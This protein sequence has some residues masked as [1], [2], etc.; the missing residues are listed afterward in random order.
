MLTIKNYQKAESLEEAWKLNQQLGNRIIGGMLWLKMGKGNIQ[1]AIDL[2]GLG[3]DGIEETKEEFRIGAMVCLRQLEVHPGLLAY[4]CGAI[5]ESLRHIVGV[6]FRNLA[7]VGG[8]IFGRFGF[9]D[10]LTMFLAMDSYVE[11][12]QGGVIPLAEFARGGYDRDVLVRVL[13]KKTPLVF[14]YESVRNSRTDFPV[15]TCCRAF[16][17]ETLEYRFAIGARP[18]RAIIIEDKEHI[19]TGEV[20]PEKAQTFG[21]YASRQV[22]TGSNM[23]GSAQYRSHLVKVLT[24]RTIVPCKST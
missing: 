14:Q 13:V 11:L 20:T 7:T 4:T 19:L 2:S 22:P 8:S 17:P 15:L 9:S 23:R 3:L 10:V 21:I 16:W 5:R 12:Y 18:G 24:E 6:Q 1:T